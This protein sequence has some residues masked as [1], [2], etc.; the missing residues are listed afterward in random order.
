YGV[1]F[2]VMLYLTI[3]P[4][5]AAPRT[6]A[7]AY[8]IGFAPFISEANLDVGLF[9]FTVVFF[10]ITLW[11]SL[12]PAKLVDRIGN[13]LAPALVILLAVVIIIISDGSQIGIKL[14]TFSLSA[15]GKPGYVAVALL[16]LIY[17]VIA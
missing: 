3:G 10:G 8:E 13:I 1:L 6:G 5:F 17:L 9:I 16:G 4:F 11:L 2:T 12:N 7:V 15:S 14:H